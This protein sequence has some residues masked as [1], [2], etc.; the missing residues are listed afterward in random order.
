MFLGRTEIDRVHPDAG[1]L[2]K[3]QP[4]RRRDD[5]GRHRLQHMQQCVGIAHFARKRCRV[6]LINN[7]DVN[8]RCSICGD[9]RLEAWPGT[10]V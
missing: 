9:L 4:G 10:I 1:L 2:D 5:I 3:L 6:A 8:V 7:N